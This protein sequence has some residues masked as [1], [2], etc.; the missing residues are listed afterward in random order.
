[1]TMIVGDGPTRPVERTTTW[2][3]FAVVNSPVGDALHLVASDAA[4]TWMVAGT[5]VVVGV[6]VSTFALGGVGGSS[7][8]GLTAASMVATPSGSGSTRDTNGSA[9]TPVAKDELG[10]SS[11]DAL[12][13]H[14]IRMIA[15][16][17]PA[18]SSRRIF[19]S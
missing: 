6:D 7:L 11:G 9:P 12:P 1:M 13:P 18:L 3:P 5:V 19:S 8:A 17:N 4:V 14:P 10:A 2:R 15:I 16:T